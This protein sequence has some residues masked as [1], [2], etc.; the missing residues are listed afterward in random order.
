MKKFSFSLERVLTYKEQ[1]EQ[2]LRNEHGQ[3]VKKVRD[4]E[5]EIS[6]LE[7]EFVQFRESAGSDGIRQV[8][9]ARLRGRS[10]YMNLLI[11][12]IGREKKALGELKKEEEQKREAVIH[13]KQETQSIQM[14]RDKKKQEYD[15]AEAKARELEIEEFV[16]N[17]MI[18][19]KG[20]D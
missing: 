13:A 15:A 3:A 20:K 16:S 1:V 18:S 19:A 2:S 11:G 14:L 6:C 9:A 4:K 10:D 12:R 7:D 8:S 17:R 5:E